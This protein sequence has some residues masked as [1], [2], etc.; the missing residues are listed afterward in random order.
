MA[1]SLFACFRIKILDRIFVFQEW[2]N[3]IR[4]FQL[5][6]HFSKHL[7]LA[8]CLMLR[9]F[10]I[11][12]LRLMVYKHRKYHRHYHTRNYMCTIHPY[13]HNHRIIKKRYCHT[14]FCSFRLHKE[15]WNRPQASYDFENGLPWVS[16][17]VL[18]KFCSLKSLM[19]LYTR[20]LSKIGI[21]KATSKLYPR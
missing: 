11:W 5:E 1:I 19:K 4:S 20:I 9:R 10:L 21:L 18:I 14:L 16:T 17:D 8:L 12:L 7:H 6:F 2:Y 13:S 3:A 15:N